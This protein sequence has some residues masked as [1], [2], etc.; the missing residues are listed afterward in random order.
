[1]AAE[2]RPYFPPLFLVIILF[3]RYFIS[4]FWVNERLFIFSLTR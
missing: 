4:S 3:T 2:Q 1:M